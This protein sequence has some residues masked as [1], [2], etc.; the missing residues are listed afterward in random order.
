MATF[1]GWH[2]GV[3]VT[4]Q[5]TREQDE[6]KASARQATTCSE[7]WPVRQAFHQRA[8]SKLMCLHNLH[9]SSEGVRGHRRFT[10]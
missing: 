2:E 1:G 9:P 5:I 6:Q 4:K 8:S 7:H 10:E 3:F